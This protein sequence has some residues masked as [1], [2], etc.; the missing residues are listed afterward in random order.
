MKKMNNTHNVFK[1]NTDILT[2]V[3]SNILSG[4]PTSMLSDCE[5]SLN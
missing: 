5:F 2:H 3:P 4:I 1:T